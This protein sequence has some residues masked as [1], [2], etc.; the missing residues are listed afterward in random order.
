MLLDLS[1]FTEEKFIEIK[2]YYKHIH[3]VKI[4]QITQVRKLLV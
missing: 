4:K 2:M 1:Y 3:W